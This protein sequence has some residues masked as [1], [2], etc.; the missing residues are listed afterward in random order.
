MRR[1]VS[2]RM[3]N[4]RI[5]SKHGVKHRSLAVALIVLVAPV[6]YPQAPNS[7]GDGDTPRNS[8]EALGDILADFSTRVRSYFELRSELE[9]GLP[10]RRVTNDPE[11]I[12]SAVRALAER[13]RVARAEG[14][15]GDF[16]TPPIS[17][18]FRKALLIEI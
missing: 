4:P 10:T 8:V 7:H 14:R 3:S 12:R 18:G 6:G 2:H 1:F 9:K 11:E 17:A 15:Q 16:F 13:I 5:S